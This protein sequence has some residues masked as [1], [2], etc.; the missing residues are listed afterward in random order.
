M[1]FDAYMQ[2][3]DMGTYRQSLQLHLDEKCAGNDSR[4]E[5]ERDCKILTNM[6]K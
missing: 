3:I 6:A 4:F 1:Q 2:H 5:Q